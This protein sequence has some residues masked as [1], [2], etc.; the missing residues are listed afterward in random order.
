M[1]LAMERMEEFGV[2]QHIA[3][4]VIPTGY[5]FNLDGS[6]LYIALATLF[7]AQMAGVHMS[8]EQQ[9]LMLFSLML[10][11]KGVAGVPKAS[12]VVLAAT[13]S[14]FHLP[15]EG[16]AVIL[17]VDHFLD[18]GRTTINLIGNCVAAAVVGR[19]EGVLDD[20]KMDQFTREVQEVDEVAALS[21]KSDRLAT[22][23][24]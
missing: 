14:S 10:T 15:M 5:S 22:A 7:V 3:A 16:I 1:P 24:A 20:A 19:W 11:T 21:V 9:M 13:L 12:L 17:G 8:W 2:P 4:F 6:T 23:K 18:M